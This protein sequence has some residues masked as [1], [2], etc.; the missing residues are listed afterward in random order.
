MFF[1]I[2]SALDDFNA[3]GQ[4]WNLRVES[5]VEVLQGEMP[6]ISVCQ[7]TVYCNGQSTYT[8]CKHNGLECVIPTEAEQEARIC[9]LTH[10]SRCVCGEAYDAYLEEK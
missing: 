2:N 8:C 5:G 10:R 7:N 9:P 1:L 6:T 4:A 3:A